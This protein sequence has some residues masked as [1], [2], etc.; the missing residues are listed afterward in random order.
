V[1]EIA[2]SIT[3]LTAAAQP[4][5]FVWQPILMLV[6]LV[7]S[8]F[9]SA[10]ETA[11]FNLSP[12][13]I[14]LLGQSKRR[15]HKLT[16]EL[17]KTPKQLL[18]CLLGGNMAV[19]VL[20]YAI[21]SVLTVKVRQQTGI[22]AAAVTGALSFCVLILFGEIFPKSLAYGA[23]KTI[24]IAAAAPALLCM[25]LFSPVFFVLNLLIIEPVLRLVLGTGRHPQ[26]ITIKEFKLLIEQIQKRGLITIDENKLLTEVIDLGQLKIRDCLRPRVDMVTC[27]ITDPA[28]KARDL[29]Q[30][31]QMVKVAVYLETIDNI[32]GWVSLRKVLLEPDKPL[33][34]LM[35]PAYFV[36]E[37][38][39][40]DSM[41]QQF[42]KSKTDTTIVVDE[43]G[44]IAGTIS[45]EDIAE[46][47]LGPIEGLPEIEPVEQIGPLQYR[48]AGGLAIHDWA[49]PF[50]IDVPEMR[51]STIA[52]LVTAALGKIPKSGD[53]AYI[54]NLHFTVERVRKHRIET[55]ILNLEP[56]SKN[57]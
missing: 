31:N 57:G 36:P 6:L 24:S 46:E 12:R 17:L 8:A 15:L 54:K 28:Q 9:F 56:V 27:A 30:K 4:I 50:G 13:T 51:I 38:K 34:E 35:E 32:V 21:A 23:S 26:P 16:A 5:D 53:T 1:A 2:L 48:L 22:T 52:G 42:R 25:K 33:E 3:Y 7:C 55:V 44:G 29:M 41:L 11:L 45:L 49:E 18:T 37:Q 14:N 40:V 19:N 47:L 10:S 20:F 39:K 43:Y